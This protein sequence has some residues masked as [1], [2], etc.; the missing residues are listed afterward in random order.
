MK[1]VC[2]SISSY[3]H[4]QR[5]LERQSDELRVCKGAKAYSEGPICIKA[6]EPFGLNRIHRQ[7]HRAD[8][9]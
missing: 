5:K 2:V 3:C 9:S 7:L 4:C 6:I 8:V 1:R